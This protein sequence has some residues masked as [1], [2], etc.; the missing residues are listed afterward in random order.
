MVGI[1][2]WIQVIVPKREQLKKPHQPKEIIT[3]IY[4][5]LIVEG[6][7]SVSYQRRVVS[8]VLYRIKK[9]FGLE[10]IPLKVI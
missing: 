1:F 7:W 6:F 3:N 5:E 8:L 4:I 9:L 2:S 10:G